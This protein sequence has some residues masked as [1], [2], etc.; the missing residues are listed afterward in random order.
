E[1]T[2]HLS[3]TKE[4]REAQRGKETRKSIKGLVQKFTDRTIDL[5]E[6]KQKLKS[7]E[8]PPVLS[9]KTLVLSEILDRID[10]DRDNSRLFVLLRD[11]CGK[12]TDHLE[13]VLEEFT[14]AISS[15]KEK[16]LQEIK[17]DI[18]NKYGIGGSAV[19]PNLQADT[20]WLKESEK[21][22]RVF[23]EKLSKETASLRP[24]GADQR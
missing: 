15:A 3:L 14:Q 2:K 8:Q 6:F 19:V 4:E 7:L 23:R 5:D 9:I 21:T 18:S 1:K 10:T 17:H 24:K 13:A 12:N 11:V 20:L 22:R 16:R